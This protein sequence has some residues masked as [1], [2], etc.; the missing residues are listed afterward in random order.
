MSDVAE[1]NQLVTKYNALRQEIAKIIV[2]QDD[3]VN[4]ILISIFSSADISCPPM[5]LRFL[6]SNLVSSFIRAV[7]IEDVLEYTSDFFFMEE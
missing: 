4:Q 1:I 2:G 5:E 3:V 6:D 7:I